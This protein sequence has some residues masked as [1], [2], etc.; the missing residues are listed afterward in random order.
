M[1]N[2]THSIAELDQM[3]CDEAGIS[4]AKFNQMSLME[5]SKLR[6]KITNKKLKNQLKK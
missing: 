1:L 6:R 3:F 5:K 2:I 4:L